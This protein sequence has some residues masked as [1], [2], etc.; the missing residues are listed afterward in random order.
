MFNNPE[1]YFSPSLIA[2]HMRRREDAKAGA[3][4]QVSGTQMVII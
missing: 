3:Q 2:A 4:A 1:D